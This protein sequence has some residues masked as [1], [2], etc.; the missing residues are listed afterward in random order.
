MRSKSVLWLAESKAP[1]Q[2][3]HAI[4]FTYEPLAVQYQQTRA[5]SFSNKSIGLRNTARRDEQSPRCSSSNRRKGFRR[6][7]IL[8]SLLL[9]HMQILISDI[10]LT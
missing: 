9:Y 6:N 5:F 7:D 4:P 10:Q 1:I 8:H 3:F 2:N